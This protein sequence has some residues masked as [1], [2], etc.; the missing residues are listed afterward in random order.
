M[1][2]SKLIDRFLRGEPVKPKHQA[3]LAALWARGEIFTLDGEPY[4][5]VEETERYGTKG[6]ETSGVAP[7]EAAPAGL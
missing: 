6:S 7:I 2:D 4:R 3:Q 5:R 1:T